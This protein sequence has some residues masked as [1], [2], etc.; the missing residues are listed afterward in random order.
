MVMVPGVRVDADVDAVD[1][2]L[3]VEVEVVGGVELAAVVAAAPDG[4]AG[5]GEV[6]AGVVGGAAIAAGVEDFYVDEGGVLA[7]GL[8][9]E[10]ADD[11]G[12]FDLGGGAGGGEL[13]AGCGLAGVAPYGAEGAG[14]EFYVGEGEDP[15][16]VGFG[17]YADGFVVEEELYGLGVGDT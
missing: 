4:G 12:E 8:Q 15:A 14:D 13:V 2:Q 5:A 3:G 1:A 6:D 9:A 7:V 11:G 10:G 16:V 17:V